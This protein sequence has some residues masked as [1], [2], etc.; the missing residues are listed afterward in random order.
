MQQAAD[1]QYLLTYAIYAA[2][3]LI[4][5]MSCTEPCQEDRTHT[6]TPHRFMWDRES[7][8]LLR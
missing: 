3:M 2:V 7:I 8:A 4:L 5:K 6:P 1:M